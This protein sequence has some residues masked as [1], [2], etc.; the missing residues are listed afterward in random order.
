MPQT[1]AQ[2]VIPQNLFTP[3]HPLM[4]RV[5]EHR[6]LTPLWRGPRNEVA[7]VVLSSPG[8]AYLPGQSIGVVPEGRDPRTGSLYK[9]RLYSVCSESR[10][11][12]GDWQT[13]STVVVRHFWDDEKTGR[14]DIP[15]VCSKQL[16]DCGVGDIVRITGPSGKHFLLPPDFHQR[17]LIFVA[18]G[19][20]IAPYRGMLKELF[21]EAYEG[22]VFLF[23]GVKY[24]DTILYDDEFRSYLSLPNFHYVTALSREDEK[25]PFPTELP[26]PDNRMYVHVRMWQNR[27]ELSPSLA[28]PDTLVYVCG[29]KGS[30]EG[31]AQVLDRIG[32][33]TGDP[34][35]SGR[36]KAER[37]FF[38][39]VY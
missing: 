7:H 11:D 34:G 23:F 25:N 9:I 16:C 17:D 28:R 20:G 13:V 2:K 15:G 29:M 35:L 37:R 8:L 18:T 3:S 14:K 22:H 10:G 31:V 21:N 30:E 33:Q 19:T 32:D 6:I 39:E 38:V 36:L 26:T 1:L 12:Y 5:L 24:A 4:S 27:T